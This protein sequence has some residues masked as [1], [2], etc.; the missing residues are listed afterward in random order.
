[1]VPVRL[2]AR[3]SPVA[4]L[5][6][7]VDAAEGVMK[8]RPGDDRARTEDEAAE[9]LVL[10]SE[11][12]DDDALRARF[13]SWRA[14]NH[15]HAEIWARTARAYDLIGGAQPRRRG[16]WQAYA[17]GRRAQWQRLPGAQPRPLVRQPGRVAFVRSPQ[18]L[19][20]ALVATAM[21]ACLAVAL[22]PDVLLRLAADRVTGTAEVQSLALQD[23]STAYLAP[24]SALGIDYTSGERR[25]RLL[26]G[27]A[28]FD[29]ARDPA[30]PF[31]VV[32]GDASVTV[33]GTAFEV[34]RT[35]SGATVAVQRG[36]VR[37][38]DPATAP[39]ASEGL[40]AG[41][42]ARLDKGM[43]IRRG[44][45]PIDEVATWRRG[46]LV[47]RDRPVAEVIEALRPYYR[48][49]ILIRDEAFAERRVSGLYD[50]HDPVGVL[51]DLAASH[52]ATVRQI[53]PW[54]LLV[55]AQ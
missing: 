4:G 8:T 47:T 17:D 14:A 37:V 7:T 20:G 33:L 55:T 21:A 39:L 28:F 15:L 41:E 51:R 29:V 2:I 19:V 23:G 50:L 5:G 32:A 35:E 30:H 40:Q 22:L 25:I 36:H 9:W 53:S 13:E 49:V 45:M 18:R 44:A 43:T 34:R 3:S 46:E 54:V 10:L 24:Q 42:W 27:D 38:N 31:R 6:S 26:K 16:H 11:D 52:G 1:M 48:G 12:P